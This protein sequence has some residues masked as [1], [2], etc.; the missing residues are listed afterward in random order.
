[1]PSE[2]SVSLLNISF[3]SACSLFILSRLL[4]LLVA[5]VLCYNVQEESSECGN[6]TYP[7][8]ATNVKDFVFTWLLFVRRL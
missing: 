6:C 8:A 1:M 7:T 4:V 2:A 5:T 3:G